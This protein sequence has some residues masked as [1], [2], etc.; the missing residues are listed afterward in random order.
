MAH[1]LQLVFEQW[2]L[3]S[4]L[5]QVLLGVL[6]SDISLVQ[7]ISLLV[8]AHVGQFKDYCAEKSEGGESETNA[9]AGGVSWLLVLE[10]LLVCQQDVAM[11]ECEI[12]RLTMYEPTI[13]PQL[14]RAMLRAIPIALFDSPARLDEIQAEPAGLVGY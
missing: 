3:V 8:E 6:F 2:R 12:E 9:K 10:E 11:Y 5:L 14:P 7:G 1:H 4:H 13:P